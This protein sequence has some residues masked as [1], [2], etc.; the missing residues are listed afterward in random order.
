MIPTGVSERE[1]LDALPVTVH[2]VDLDGRITSATRAGAWLW[3]ALDDA[4]AREQIEHAMTLL[5]SGRSPLV[6][7]EV[8]SGTADDERVLLMQMAP[9]HEGHAIDGY[10]FTTVDITPSHRS[11]QALADAGVAIATTIDLDRTL[12]EVAQQVRRAI[13]CDALAI[14]LA[15]DDATTFRLAY[16]L[17][18]D[19]DGAATIARLQ[20]AWQSAIADGHVV[21]RR[22]TDAPPGIELTAPLRGSDAVLGAMTIVTEDADAPQHLEETTRLLTGLAAQTAVALD[23]VGLVRRAAHRRRLEAL[24]EVA[25]GVAHELRNPLFGIS[26]AAQLLRFSAKEEPVVE[27]NVG[28]ILREVER[29]NRMVTSLLD[30]GRPAALKLAPADPD[31]VWDAVLAGER[32]RLESRA[33]ALHRTRAHGATCLVDAEQLAHVFS[34][35]LVNAIAAAPEASDLT[36]AS[37][38]L[39]SGAWRC[40]L[41]NAGPPIPADVLPHVFEIFFSTKPG[42]TGIGLALS[43]RIVE[44]HHGS[45]A[46][47]STPE[48]GTTVTVTIPGTRP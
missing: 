36:L 3:E 7:W 35:I 28:R 30:F 48:R 43:Q 47:D 17:G 38:V 15:D 1:V 16:E 41:V 32:G 27:K 44:E 40:R 5:R 11:R 4:G 22:R 34:N 18:F 37:A 33:L 13:R 46:I 42:S 20:P 29:L 45:I 8:P 14:A 21:V 25:A 26:S 24:G 31:D 23:R 10:V 9:L 2:T 39:P 12:A 6:R 19:A